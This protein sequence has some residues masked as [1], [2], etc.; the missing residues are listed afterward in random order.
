MV[1]VSV[2]CV[3]LVASACGGGGAGGGDNSGPPQ[4]GGTLRY[5]LSQ[6]PTCA[7]PAQAGTN[8][9]IYLTRQ[10]VDSLTDQDPKT[11]AIVPWL[12]QRWEVSPDA[13]QFTFHLR[14]GVTFSDGTPVDAAAVRSTFDAI[15]KTLGLVK[16]PLGASYLSGY[17][18]T[19]VV[20]PL[21]AR[22]SFSGPN[23]QFLQ[24]SSTPQLGILAAKTNAET[25][26]QRCQGPVIG[27]GP[28]VYTDYQQDR[29]A[30][31]KKRTGYTW[32]SPAFAHS[33]EAYLDG[34]DFTVVPESGVRTGSIASDQLDT[35]SD[36]LPQDAAQIT[37]AGGSVLTTPNPGVPFGLQLNVTRG[38]LVDP[39]VRKALVPAINRQ[40]LVD[41][42]LGPDFKP[43]TGVL[44]SKTPG[45]T[46]LSGVRFDASA[47][48]AQLQAAGWV[49]GADG[50]RVKNG[51]RLK[52]AVLYSAVFAGN[53]AVLELVQQQLK[54]VGV[55]LALDLTSNAE[56]T[57][58]QNSGD[59]DSIYGNV[60]RADGDILRSLFSVTQRNLSHSAAIPALEQAFA[61]ELATVDTTKRNALLAT[62][63]QQLLDN[64]FYVPTIELSQAI[65]AGPKAHGVRFDA[66]ARLQFHD[67]WLSKN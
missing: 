56:F 19:T 60:T 42:V 22:V 16:A 25:V 9:T 13:T 40:E 32:S 45:Y 53:Q 52:F 36:A 24:A 33:G 11:G 41:T 15:T 18:G 48:A 66:S 65:G 30:K 54:K 8:Q 63:Q 37:G 20:D 17:T 28:F 55:D 46:K 4:T 23:A 2:L 3:A 44:A 5:G 34:I 67:T 51:A 12:A 26:E 7:D 62:A 21:T 14:P 47:A 31:L 27:S 10:V 57:A 1:S 35:I 61:G 59:Y 38:P 49:P 29:S 50:I 58:R 43:A 6:A 64:G 39:A